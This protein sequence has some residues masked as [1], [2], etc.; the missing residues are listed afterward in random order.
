[1]SKRRPAYWNLTKIG[2]LAQARLN[3]AGRLAHSGDNGLLI[4]R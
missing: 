4:E 1:M 3:A 2:L